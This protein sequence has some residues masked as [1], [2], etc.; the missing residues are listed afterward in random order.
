[1]AGRRPRLR[2]RFCSGGGAEKLSFA[3]EVH[4]WKTPGRTS[5]AESWRGAGSSWRV[6]RV[7]LRA[8]GTSSLHSPAPALRVTLRSPGPGSVA[9]LVTH[10]G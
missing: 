3:P 10:L 2:T 9:F 7:T 8:P 1:M 6:D 5:L 4:G